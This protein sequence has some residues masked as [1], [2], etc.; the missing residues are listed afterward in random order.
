MIQQS[1]PAVEEPLTLPPPPQRMS[2]VERRTPEPPQEEAA[3]E[4]DDIPLPSPD[5]VAN[6]ARK[7]PAPVHIYED[8][9]PTSAE[10]AVS[11]AE[12]ADTE[13]ADDRFIS[14]DT[15]AR[16]DQLRAEGYDVSPALEDPPAVAAEVEAAL[17]E[18]ENHMDVAAPSVEP[19]DIPIETEEEKIGR[20]HV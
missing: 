12:P 2:S 17:P 8:P 19:T 9:V 7:Q 1:A 18:Q 13:A 20:A 10:P 5:M 16:D 15:L 11:A 6:N 14:A 3:A 4:L